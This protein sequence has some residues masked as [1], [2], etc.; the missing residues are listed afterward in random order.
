MAATDPVY[1]FYTN[2]RGEII[3]SFRDGIAIVGKV[4]GI[5]RY[6][7]CS[8]ARRLW[9]WLTFE[10]R[11]VNPE[12]HKVY[13]VTYFGDIGFRRPQDHDGGFSGSH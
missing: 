7:P 2:R 9:L 13:Y 3:A 11:P 10:E 4:L 1:K 6:L 8:M 5:K 12:W